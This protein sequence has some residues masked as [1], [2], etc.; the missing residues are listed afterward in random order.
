MWESIL[1]GGKCMQSA[2]FVLFSIRLLKT[3]LLM[4]GF[5]SILAI[6]QITRNRDLLYSDNLLNT[7]ASYMESYKASN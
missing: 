3:S 4:E 5:F 7:Y 1:E 6:S 2:N